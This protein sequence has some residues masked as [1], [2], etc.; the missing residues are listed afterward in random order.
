MSARGHR[1]GHQVLD[2]DVNARWDRDIKR[3]LTAIRADEIL[4]DLGRLR[5]EWRA[6]QRRHA[7]PIP[8]QLDLF[9]NT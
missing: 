4:R 1:G 3:Q 8:G 2:D 7:L 9:T 5:R 6:Y